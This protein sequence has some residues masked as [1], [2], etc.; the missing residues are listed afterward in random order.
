MNYEPNTKDWKPGDLVIHDC[1]AKRDD[2][3]MMV[4]GKEWDHIK[5]RYNYRTAYVHQ[6]EGRKTGV[7]INA[8]EYLHCPE[9]FGIQCGEQDFRE[10][11]I[12]TLDK[13]RKKRN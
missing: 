3:L 11:L 5:D 10:M 2:M 4:V 8:K 13:G 9:R 12:A 6:E 7:W 1:D